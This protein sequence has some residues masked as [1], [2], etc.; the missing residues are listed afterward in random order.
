MKYTEKLPKTEQFFELFKTTGWNTKYE[1]TKEELFTALKN[2][3][4]SI[5]VFDKETT[6]RI[7]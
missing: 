7:W 2:S 5:S 4:Y 3:W 1:L 6:Y